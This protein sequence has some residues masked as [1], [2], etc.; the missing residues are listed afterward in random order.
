MT[1][2]VVYR[3]A[4]SPFSGYGNDGI[5]LV[6]ALM[7]QG[8]DVYLHP[9]HV[10]APLPEDVARLLTKPLQAPFDLFLHHADPGGLGLTPEQ[11][12]SAKVTVAWTMWEAS[13]LDNLKGRTNLARKL[14]SYDVLLSYDEVC[15]KAF[16]PYTSRKT[17]PKCGV[18][19]GGFDPAGWKY[20]ERDWFGERF[21]Y[22]MVGQLHERKDP[23]VAIQAFQELKEEKG[24][25]FEGAELHLKSNIR[26]LH[27]AMEETVP[28]L[29]IHY[30]V[31]PKEVLRQFYASQHI[32]LA[33]SRGEG[34]NLPALEFQ[35]TG[36]AVIATDWGGMRSWL[37]PT[38]AYPLDYTLAPV[39]PSLPGCLQ[40]RASKDHLKTL[41]WKVFTD[42]PKVKAKADL[43]AKVIPDMMSW[44]RV[45]ER[46]FRVVAERLPAER[47]T[48]LT[49]RYHLAQGGR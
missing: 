35:S 5:D 44:D 45:V 47:A 8:V 40:A 28:K 34:K 2:K 38:Y 4:L 9:T 24:H 21:A 13:S 39:A 6:R 12:R 16:V 22:C 7:A 1:L 41:M 33:P 42:R 43:A 27:P 19:Q 10:D 49:T 14:D 25:A 15:D 18:L 17:S 26:T 48:S 46:L 30:A 11:R 23:F 31:W 32:L 20:E 37:S 29:R 36:G 3:G